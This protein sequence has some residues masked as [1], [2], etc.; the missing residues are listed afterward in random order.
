MPPFSGYKTLL[1]EDGGNR[2]SEIL[3]L[4]NQITRTHI[5]ED[6]KL[7]IRHSSEKTLNLIY[8]LVRFVLYAKNLMQRLRWADTNKNQI[9]ISS[10]QGGSYEDHGL[11]CC[12]AVYFR[13]A[14][15]FRGTYHFHQACSLLIIGFLTFPVPPKRLSF[16]K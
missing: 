5:P 2:Y 13:K 12:D 1:P 9:L 16:P 8:L 14:L 15:R 7:Y 4:I 3:L 6:S 11:L 10:S